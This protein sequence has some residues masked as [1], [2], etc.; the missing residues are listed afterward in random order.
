MKNYGG[1]K[2]R[3]GN[4]P[5][6]TFGEKQLDALAKEASAKMGKPADDIKR[7]VES[8]RLS[9]ITARLSPADAKTLNEVLNDKQKLNELLSSKKAQM[10]LKNLL[11]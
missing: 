3:N 2:P 5:D 1:M 9:D 10:L 8:G 7:A 4:S 11:K 6:F